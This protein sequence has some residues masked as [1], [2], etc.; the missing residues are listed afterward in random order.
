MM[1]RLEDE[2]EKL[3]FENAKYLNELKNLRNEA[4]SSKLN[5]T[6]TTIQDFEFS[7]NCSVLA[8]NPKRSEICNREYYNENLWFNQ[9]ENIK[10]QVIPK[11]THLTNFITC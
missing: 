1:S 8:D 10:E 5:P 2:N 4:N 11:I 3:K 7:T 6:D 9:L